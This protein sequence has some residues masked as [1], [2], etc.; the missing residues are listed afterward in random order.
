MGGATLAGRAQAGGWMSKD[1]LIALAGGAASALLSLS[2]A[3]GSAIAFLIVYLAPLPLFLVGLSRGASVAAIAGMAGVTA[4]ALLVG[5]LGGLIYAA[6]NGVPAWYAIRQSLRR[7]PGAAPG[8]TAD[9][10]PVGG[11]LA[12]LS[13]A[14]AAVV[15]AAAVANLGEPGGLDGVIRGHLGAAL[16]AVAPMLSADERSRAVA[17]M[18]PVFPA[19]VAISW[20]A[21]TVANG[22]LAQW[23]LARAG[24]NLRPSP[25]LLRLTL[26]GWS[27]WPLVIAAAAALIG[28]GQFGYVARNV[29]LILWVPYFFLGLAVV[30]TLVRRVDF[31]GTLLAAFYVLLLLLSGW[32]LP[33]VA[34]LG[35]VDELV[36]LRRRFAKA[37]V[38][39]EDE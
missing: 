22:V 39:R 25:D 9:W 8:T 5:P 30:H 7:L 34:G 15:V 14:A 4:T 29:A 35:F 1:V 13:A 6:L 17:A 37:A 3:S 2:M 27:A 16:K 18:A 38:D 21:M 10:F 33:L 28:N 19:A 12:V 32:I 26:P 31:A 23:L 20:L 11:I 24:R 36:D